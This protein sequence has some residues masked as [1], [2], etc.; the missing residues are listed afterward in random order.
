MPVPMT[1]LEQCDEAR[2]L[3]LAAETEEDLREVEA[4]YKQALNSKTTKTKGE[5][6]PQKKKQKVHKGYAELS[7]LDYRKA[8]ERLSLLYC[9]SGR[10]R[11]AQKGLEYLGF[12]CRLS[13]QVLDYPYYATKKKKKKKNTTKT[14]PNAKANAAAAPCV[15]F[16][17][18]LQPHELHRLQRVF[19]DPSASYWTSHQYQVEPPSP[20][21]SYVLP[22]SNK[23]SQSNNN[24]TT[25]SNNSNNHSNKYGFMGRLAHRIATLPALVRKF[26]ALPQANYV[27]VWAHNRPHASGHQLHFD[28]D[29]EGR[30]G[31]IKN[32]IV[33]TILYITGETDTDDDTEDDT[34]D[35]HTIAGG[36]SLVTNQRL[37]ST[38]LATQGWL[39]HPKEQRLVAFDGTV[40][41]G[42]IPGK[43]VQPGRRVTLMMAFWKQIDIRQGNDNDKSS[44]GAARPF[45]MQGHNNQ[46]QPLDEWVRDLLMTNDKTKNSFSDSAKAMTESAPIVVDTVYERLNG[47]PWNPK[48]DGMPDY[49]QVFQGF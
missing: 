3:W 28:S 31:V 26:P 5:Q 4:L 7:T 16:D 11:T 20:Y 19:G 34:E 17:N 25:N 48:L 37:T 21:F 42:V 47:E 33:S 46:G 43:G 39:A 8:G 45:P 41:H 14:T 12:N 27:E 10:T 23:K 30:G 38:Q 40:L 24:N 2:R 44:P 32:P 6:P 35:N 15:I 13:Q 49:E 29:N 22:L 18:F 36:P 1:A 9:Q